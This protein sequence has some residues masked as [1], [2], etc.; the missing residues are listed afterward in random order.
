MLKPFFPRGLYWRAALIVLLPVVTM[1]L[2]LSI[3]F[4]QRHYEGV[5]RQMTGN[6]VLVAR[7]ILHRVDAHDDPSGRARVAAEAARAFAMEVMPDVQAPTERVDVS[8]AFYDIAGRMAIRELTSGLP[9]LAAIR[10]RGNQ[11]TLW[12]TGQHGVVRMDFLLRRISASNPHQLLVL[13]FV[14]GLVMSVISFIYLK[15]QV[16]PIRRLSR[17]AEAFGRGEVVP[18]RVTG[19]TEVR[20]AGTAF[21]QMR[22]RI[23]R[24]IEQRTL[25][26]SGVSH[27]LRTPLTRM[28]LALSLMDDEA[29]AAALLGDVT[30][31]EALI[32]RFLE[33]AR[34]EAVEP[35]EPTDL[36]ALVTRRV[37]E[38]ARAG[39]TVSAKTPGDGPILELRPQLFGRALDNLIANGMRYGRKVQVGVDVQ[40][41][42][43]VVT[44]EDDGPGI[45]P[46]QYDMAIRP[47]VRLDPAR[48][49]SQGSGAGLGLA[50]VVDAMR[51]HGG[52]LE[53]DQSTT[54]GFGGLAA[55]LILPI[56]TEP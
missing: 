18:L 5:T 43:V 42:R 46:T 48:G 6:F 19:A 13:V 1:L 16:R 47:F 7:D 9:E 35:T 21:L 55:R 44:V 40:P 41:T 25:L 51:S 34:N 23:E 14:I 56:R 38:A 49:A 22:E 2:V 24:H 29:E 15:N 50:I 26:L 37:T 4:I 27:D 3:G 8:T 39:R 52:K 12:L 36:G 53:L 10:L 54:P 30:E 31:M 20:A 33:F 45:D 11:V 17:A 28:R 32:D